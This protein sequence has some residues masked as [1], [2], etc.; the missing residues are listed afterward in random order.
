MKKITPIF[1]GFL[2]FVAMLSF[3]QCISTY[4]YSKAPLKLGEVYY[5]KWSSAARWSGSGIN[6]FIPIISN[7]NQIILDSVYFKNQQVKLEYINKSL[8]VGRFKTATNK[9][10]DIIMSS[11]PY[12][13]YGNSSLK[14]NTNSNACVISYLKG[15]KIKYFK[16]FKI[17]KK[18]DKARVEQYSLPQ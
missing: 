16:L 3:S 18:E 9:H 15:R 2:L 5:T 17:L 11:N 14:K 4:K 10:Q 8:A 1:V 6:I 7:P 12:A 13:E